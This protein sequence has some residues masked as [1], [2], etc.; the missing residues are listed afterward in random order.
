MAKLIT[1]CMAL[2]GASLLLPSE[3]SYD[4]WAWL[5]W[6][7]EI[8]QLELDTTGGPSWKPLPVAFTLL[9][10]PFGELDDAL[11][12]ALWTV[13][14][15]A[16]A[17]LALALAF[18][19]AAR[20]VG[21][22]RALRL[23]A[24]APAAFGLVLTPEWIRYV[25]H[26]N[27]A[28]LAVALMLWALERHLDGR[29]DHAL[30]LG[31]LACLARPEVFPFV[32]LYALLP[33][34]PG[35]PRR[36]PGPPCRAP[37][38]PRRAPV[39]A[40]GLLVLVPLAWIVPEWLGSGNPLD[41]AA[42]ARGEPSWSLSH[43][44]V[45]WRRALVRVHNHAGIALELL[46]LVAVAFAVR[47]RERVT[48]VL[49]GAALAEVV[50]FVA[51]TE[52]GFSG[53]ARYVLPA[54]V[55]LCLLGAVG[56]ARLVEAA[57]GRAASIA[58]ATVAAAIV[59]SAVPWVDRR[60]D[61]MAFEAREVRERMELHRDLARAVDAAGGAGT[62]NAF[63]PATANRAFH[64]RLAWELG[65]PIREVELGRG[66]GVVFRSWRELIAGPL[67]VR[68]RARGRR[69]LARV[70]TWRVY[71]REGIPSA[72]F[73]HRLQG[74]HNRRAG[75]RDVPTRVVTR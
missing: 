33:S 4:P 54:L 41:A 52:A 69:V 17:L 34:R 49:A 3:P 27:E 5:V 73:T 6:G 16:G 32:A 39:L 10:S 64:T 21:G 25:G 65:I 47:R 14:A 37:E 29:R 70:G 48:L 7:R 9:F 12:V 72:V 57:A 61:R 51:M 50:L 40:A 8:A 35:P 67:R 53:N 36:A 43:A 46:S 11:P 2:A 45:P 26:A 71:R 1:A 59:L 18:R 28:P 55:I 42:Q 23:P 22:R 58:A 31:A 66:R 74:F 19:L 62:I 20:L 44:E 30:V 68:G 24:G 63:G 38:P 13:V 75:G 60:V 56:A 15:R